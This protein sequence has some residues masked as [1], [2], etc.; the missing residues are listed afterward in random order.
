MAD[1]PRPKLIPTAVRLFRII[2]PVFPFLMLSFLVILLHSVS[3]KGRLVPVKEL[4]DNFNPEGFRRAGEIL[5]VLS[6]AAA[7][8]KFFKEWVGAFVQLRIVHNF[9][10]LL[11]EKLLTLPLRFYHHHKSGDVLS[12]LNNDVVATEGA[13][14]FF[15]E[16]VWVYSSEI[17]VALAI[18]FWA[19]WQLA[20]GALLLIPLVAIPLRLVGR[21][22]WKTR[23]RS[24]EYLGEVSDSLVQIYGG[25]KTIK[26]YGTEQVEMR[27]YEERNRGFLRKALS[28]IRAR[29]VAESLVE[30]IVAI[31][32]GG[33]LL[34]LDRFF[35]D[36]ELTPGGMVMFV[37]ALAFMMTPLRNFTRSYNRCIESL[38]ALSRL[39]EILDEGPEPPDRGDAEDPGEVRTVRY[40]DVTF[41][42][43]VEPVLRAVSLEAR[44]GEIIAIVGG[45]GAGKSTLVDLLMKFYEPQSGAILVDGRDIRNYKRAGLLRRIALC[46]Q[47][48]FLF[49]SS[50]EANIRYGNPAA[51][52]EQVAEARRLANLMELDP[53]TQVGERG[54]NVSGGERQRIA[55]ARALVRRPSILILDEPTSQLDATSERL[56]QQAIENVTRLD[57]QKRIT[58]V[59]AHRL[60]TV[61]N[62]DRILVLDKGRLVEQGSHTELLARGGIYS[63]LFRTQFQ[64]VG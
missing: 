43:D 16:D 38:A 22:V 30:V 48:P 35:V 46:T 55:L 40:D 2:R 4:L 1:A 62:A 44:A 19:N 34:F 26:A 41:A 51:T 27:N 13:T 8:L 17:V 9:R 28:S 58:F 39:F 5:I 49:N 61:Q 52:A 15:Y 45:S 50:V 25:I 32:I 57:T 31:V 60:S 6:L 37:G 12:R 10:I 53:A 47:D 23:R 20:A 29:A 11:A 24:F 3:D 18:A 42:Y 64:L 56:V 59:I 33:I 21:K 7:V 36:L 14:K 63:T 54:V